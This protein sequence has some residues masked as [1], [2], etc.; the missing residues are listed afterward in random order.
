MF[1]YLFFAILCAFSL[2]GCS[3]S[4]SNAVEP[5]SKIKNIMVSADGSLDV[6]D[7]AKIT[8]LRQTNNSQEVYKTL[9]AYV[10]DFSGKSAKFI[11]VIPDGNKFESYFEPGEYYLAVVSKS[12]VDFIKANVN[13]HK[14]Y[15]AVVNQRF[16]GYKFSAYAVKNGDKYKFSFGHE[17]IKALNDTLRPIRLNYD[18]YK[19]H[20]NEIEKAKLD[21]VLDKYFRRWQRISEKNRDIRTIS[22]S[23]DGLF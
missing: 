14:N 10:Y 5:V 21:A 2:G 13:A 15:Y 8:F 1:R 18:V 6:G 4:L 16:D 12:S 19:Y 11:G 17:D 7:K 22:P 9:N 23:D 20:A 3:M